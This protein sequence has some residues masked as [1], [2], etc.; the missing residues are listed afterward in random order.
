M[1]FSFYLTTFIVVIFCFN[2]SAMIYGNSAYYHHPRNHDYH[3]DQPNPNYN[4]DYTPNNFFEQ[5]KRYHYDD[6]YDHPLPTKE[7]VEDQWQ[8]PRPHPQ[9]G[10]IAPGTRPW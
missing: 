8:Q 3:N 1:N 5:Q 6:V 9:S 2:A 10:F 7:R 4:P